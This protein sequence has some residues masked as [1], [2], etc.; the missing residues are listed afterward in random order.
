M[1]LSLISV[2]QMKRPMNASK[3]VVLLMI[4]VKDIIKFEA[5][6]RCDSKIKH[7][8]VEVVNTYDNMFQEPRGLASKRGIQYEIQL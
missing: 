1:N 4:K 6:S 2:G 7:E 5:F 8:L 3:N